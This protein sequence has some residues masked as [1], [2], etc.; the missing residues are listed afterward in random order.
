MA[1][2]N[3]GYGRAVAVA[4]VAVAADQLT[5]VIARDAIDP[6]DGIDLILGVKLVRVA[7]EG[8]AFGML[9]G[10]G[11]LLLVLIGSAFA[12]LLGYFLVSADRPNLWLPIGLLVGGAVGN[13][14][15][16]IRDGAVTD[17]IDPP[18]WPAFNLADVEIT[19]GVVILLLM[20]LRE[21]ERDDG[22]PPVEAAE[23][24]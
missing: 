24:R 13:L 12:I 21:P 17:F 22:E 11:P 18:A 16:R 9:E 4:A 6:G 8:I 3:P 23:G 7:N 19:V 20:F 1:S 15:D 2:V 10:A 14:I 5:K